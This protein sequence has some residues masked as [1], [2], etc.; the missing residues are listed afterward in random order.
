ML[1]SFTFRERSAIHQIVHDETWL[2]SER[3]G[4]RVKADDSVVR[5]NVCRV[6]L[7]IGAQLRASTQ[8]ALAAE[9]ADAPTP[10]L[11]EAA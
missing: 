4:C 7:R 6:V 8:R 10:D 9:N 1:D 11:P 5:E 2:E 3:R